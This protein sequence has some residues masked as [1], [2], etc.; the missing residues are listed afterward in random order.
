MTAAT[1]ME[2]NITSSIGRVKLSEIIVGCKTPIFLQRSFSTS[3]MSNNMGLPTNVISL[4]RDAIN[5]LKVRG[6]C[7]SPH[8]TFGYIHK[9]K[10]VWTI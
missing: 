5:V 7:S 2:N 10:K 8:L 3:L 1:S 9:F 4:T 6:C